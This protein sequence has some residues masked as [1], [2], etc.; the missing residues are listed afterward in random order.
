[1]TD[2]T[3][4]RGFATEPALVSSEKAERERVFGLAAKARRGTHALFATRLL[5]VLFTLASV[6]ILARLIPPRDFGIWAMAYLP[7]GLMMIVLASGLVSSIV[8]AKT[9]T[10]EQQDS[11][12]W[13]SVGISLASAALLALAAPLLASFYDAPLLRP[14][15][16]ASCLSLA[17]TG[18]GLVH[19]ALLRRH[20]EYNKLAVIEGGGMFCGLVAT[21][22]GA[23]FWRDVWA[24]V[25]GYIAQAAW[26]SATAI[27]LFRWLPG[28]PGRS[29][30]RINLALSFQVT[31]Y[32]VLTYAG[33][34]VGMV[35]GYRFG[36]ADLGYFNRGHQL[37]YL[38]CFWFLTPITEVGFALL[39]RLKPDHTYRDAYIALARRVSVLFIPFTAVLPIVAADLI[40]GLLGP[41]WTPVSPILAWLAPAIFGQAFASLFAQLMTSQGRGDELRRWAVADLILRAAGAV[42]G[43]QFG[44]VG[45]AAG[46]SLAT[47]FVTVP[48]MVWIAGRS[49]PVKARHH[50]VAIWPGVLL[51]LAAILGAALAVHGAQVLALSAGWAR[52]LF[53]GG[54]AALAWAVLCL[55]LRPAR[56]ALLGKGLAHA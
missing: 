48:L 53:V 30:S 35:A 46:F 47:F 27:V 28:R 36:A 2:I 40:L 10:P 6:T 8:Q 16:W 9:L 44:I 14:V 50:L 22:A 21:V 20:L 37:S 23:Y 41:N 5:S 49:G 45:L 1:M 34:N 7:L 24:L 25:A 13:A 12:F 52:L 31:L 17:V 55:V 19:T 26:I 33:N 54:S 11:Y 18:L 4:K 39:C 42:V 15:V 29:G 56:D 3:A 38:S 32:N 51:A 43:S